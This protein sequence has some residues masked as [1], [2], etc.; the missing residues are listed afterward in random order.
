MGTEDAPS[1]TERLMDAVGGAQSLALSL[2]KQATSFA[3]EKIPPVP[4]FP[5]DV[6]DAPKEIVDS[7]FEQIEEA[8]ADRAPAVRDV[9]HQQATFVR[10][11]FTSIEPI[12]AALA[13][14][15][16]EAPTR[17]TTLAD[18]PAGGT[19]DDADVGHA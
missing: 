14:D 5:R 6:L 2:T 18:T 3:A 11:V 16:G 19:A 15:T 1:M 9:I 7:V 13:D 12:V 10:G 8:L 4:G 17:T